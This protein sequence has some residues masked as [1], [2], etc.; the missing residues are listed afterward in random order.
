LLALAL[1]T[2]GGWFGHAW[3]QARPKPVE[4]SLTVSA[5]ALTD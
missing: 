1:L 2:V 5:P 3:W 4:V